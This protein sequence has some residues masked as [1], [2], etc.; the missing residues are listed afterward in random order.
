[1]NR[2]A[3]SKTQKYAL[4]AA[5]ALYLSIV[6]KTRSVDNTDPPDQR[7]LKLVCAMMSK[8]LAASGTP[9]SETARF[10][11]RVYR[12]AGDHIAAKEL[13]SNPRLVMDDAEVLQLRSE[14]VGIDD[15][16]GD[17]ITVLLNHDSDSWYHWLRFINHV[18]KDAEGKK[19]VFDLAKKV[20]ELDQ[21]DKVKKRGP[22]LSK[23]EILYRTEDYD[24][25][26]E[27]IV[28][29]FHHFGEKSICAHDLRPYICFLRENENFETVFAKCSAI[30]EEKGGCYDVTLCWLK[31]WFNRL[32]AS[33]EELHRRY[34]TLL[35]S[36]LEVTDR[37]AGDDYILLAVLKLLP[38][39]LSNQKSSFEKGIALLKSIT[40]LE[41]GLSR[42]LFN[43]H[44][45]LLLIHLY[46]EV[47][48][49]ERVEALWNSLGVKHVQ[50]STLSHMVLR[51]LFEMGHHDSLSSLLANVGRLWNEC[52]REI[53]ECTK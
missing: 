31:L 12:D 47:G 29:Y 27:N 53:P 16:V 11:T 34:S 41:A 26:A 20:M 52:D 19:K 4:W 25:L 8:A 13:I 45:K 48:G 1:M 49:I 2:F 23:L 21:Q 33:P 5:A 22:L 38:P 36:E 10:A 6:S 35:S 28:E 17:S 30:V 46:I 43:Y 24:C 18:E 15:S 50:I 44:F 37:Q 40:L 9:S 32:D 51:P 14:L 3:T 7:I 42:S 39:S